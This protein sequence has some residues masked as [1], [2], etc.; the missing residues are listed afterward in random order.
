MRFRG[1]LA[2]ARRQRGR[3]ALTCQNAL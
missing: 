2:V 1:D 3:S